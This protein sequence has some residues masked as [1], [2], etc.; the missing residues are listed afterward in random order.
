VRGATGIGY[1]THLDSP[2]ALP[3][4]S[5]ALETELAR[6]NASIRELTDVLCSLP[7]AVPV[8]VGGE[9]A[10]NVSC[11]LRESSDSSWLFVVHDSS[12]PR[13]ADVRFS[14][15]QPILSVEDWFEGRALASS[16]KSFSDHLGP[17]GARIA[18]APRSQL[19]HAR[20]AGR[21]PAV[22]RVDQCRG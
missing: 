5:S 9:A 8:D 12:D 19:W 1:A 20:G 18:F 4:L 17:P 11:M 13:G 10:A 16:D 6:T 14:L 22:G 21:V 2:D 3:S 15:E 7:P